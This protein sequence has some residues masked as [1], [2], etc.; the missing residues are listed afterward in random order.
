MTKHVFLISG[1]NDAREVCDI[2]RNLFPDGT[3]GPKPEAADAVVFE[4]ELGPGED[5]FQM[6][7]MLADTLST[8]AY[9]GCD[10]A[11]GQTLAEAEEALT[12][13]RIF[14]GKSRV[15]DYDRLTYERLLAHLS[16]DACRAYL[17]KTLGG[18]S[19][20]ELYGDLQSTVD[21]LIR[22]NLNVS[23]TAREIFI[24]RN[25][26]LYRISRIEEQ[27]GLDVRKFAD[28][29]QL[30]TAML[31]LR[32]LHYLDETDKEKCFD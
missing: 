12:V 29:M 1:V 19:E 9:R 18:L 6:A 14:A 17:Q 21:A 24:H 26:M 23:E 7:E 20:D 10:V 25:T 5:R 31:L 27:T 2:V 4:S 32:Y 3:G 30:K 8:E 22:Y 11:V 15:F 16:K 28:A 13:G